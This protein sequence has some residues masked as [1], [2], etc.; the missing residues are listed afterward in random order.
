MASG[1]ARS[2]VPAWLEPAARIRGAAPG[3]YRRLAARFG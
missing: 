1:R 3:I 2:V